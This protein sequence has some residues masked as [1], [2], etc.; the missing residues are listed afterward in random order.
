[1]VFSLHPTEK[2]YNPTGENEMY[3]HITEDILMIGGGGDGPAL[4][5]DENLNICS[6]SS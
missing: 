3:V 2:F 4:T 6:S 1:M 5:V